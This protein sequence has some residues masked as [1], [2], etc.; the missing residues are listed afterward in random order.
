MGIARAQET[1]KARRVALSNF[2]YGFFNNIEERAIVI[3]P[4]K[5]YMIDTNTC[6]NYLIDPS[7]AE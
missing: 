5:V 7:Y 4:L 3:A 1:R 6:I 2:Y